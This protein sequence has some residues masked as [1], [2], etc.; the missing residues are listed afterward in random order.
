METPSRPGATQEGATM[1]TPLPPD[2]TII[3]DDF[4]GHQP[5]KSIS[6][7][8]CQRCGVENRLLNQ[9]ECIDCWNERIPL[10]KEFE[11]HHDKKAQP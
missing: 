3:I 7:G 2:L 6:I 11:T 10:L 8:T 4:E 1:S 5:V 9:G